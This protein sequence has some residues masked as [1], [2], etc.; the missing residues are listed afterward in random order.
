MDEF[1]N[2]SASFYEQANPFT[3]SQDISIWPTDAFM[4]LQPPIVPFESFELPDL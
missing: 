3:M 2:L 1:R 4:D